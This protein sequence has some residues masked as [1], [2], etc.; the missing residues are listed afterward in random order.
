MSLMILLLSFYSIKDS[1]Q[2]IG[3]TTQDSPA[4]L[5][6]ELAAENHRIH[7]NVVLV[8]ESGMT[9]KYVRRK[10]RQPFNKTRK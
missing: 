1:A 5:V 8:R 2:S 4:Y 3:G 7:R 9:Q 10:Q 6:S